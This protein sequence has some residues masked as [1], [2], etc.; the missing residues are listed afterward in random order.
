MYYNDE[1]YEIIGVTATYT[2][3]IH[4]VIGVCRLTYV[5]IEYGNNVPDY[6]KDTLETHIL[7]AFAEDEY[8]TED[9]GWRKEAEDDIA[10]YTGAGYVEVE[11]E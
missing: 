8:Y 3:D 4:D 7:N 1:E 9:S 10:E 6:M 2:E 5:D 11:L